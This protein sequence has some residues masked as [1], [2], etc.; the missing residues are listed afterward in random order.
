MGKPTFVKQICSACAQ[1][2]MSS[3][4]LLEAQN[5]EKVKTKFPFDQVK[6][7]I[8]NFKGTPKVLK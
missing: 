2:G 3:L 7:E 1:Q 8:A 6:N 5:E 4:G